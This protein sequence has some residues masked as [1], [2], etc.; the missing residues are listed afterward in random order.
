ML[1]LYVDESGSLDNPD[2]HFVVGGVAVHESQTEHVRRRVEVAV[3]RNV[4]ARGLELHA[5]HI[6]TGKG[7]WGR[8]PREPRDGLLRDIPRLL[9]TLGGR[10][11]GGIFA[12]VWSPG[13]VPG[14]DPLERSYEELLLR[15]TQMLVRR[16]NAGDIEYGLVVADRAKYEG[17]VQPI[18]ERWRDTG[19]RFAR[20]RRLSEVPLFIDS[21]ASRLVQ[22]ADFVAH[23][24]YRQ[25]HAGDASLFGPLLP[26]FDNQ[27]GVMHG[28]VHLTPRHRTCPCPACVTRAVKRSLAPPAAGEPLARP[29]SSPP[30]G[31]Q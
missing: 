10:P 13:A 1:L 17:I 12:V 5:Q 23:G 15:F 8:I 4:R 28:L 11:N 6:R 29:P 30:S 14:I 7:P 22:L 3:A 20:L 25:Y 27:N 21:A 19:T 16:S 26:A 31:A 24:V 2:D 9:G 18:V